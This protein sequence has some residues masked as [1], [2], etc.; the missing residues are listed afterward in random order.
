MQASVRFGLGAAAVLVAGVSLAGAAFVVPFMA[1]VVAPTA[2]A[3]VVPAPGGDVALGAA[4]AT[5]SP[6]AAATSS[7]GRRQRIREFMQRYRN[8]DGTYD[9]G[10]MH[11]DLRSGRISPPVGGSGSGSP[12][13]AGGSASGAG[14][15]RDA[16]G[17]FY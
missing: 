5:A 7:A 15:S 2:T 11:E 8:A 16:T 14:P 12:D 13:A 17:V 9:M 4:P 6:S 10:R 1:A 3:M